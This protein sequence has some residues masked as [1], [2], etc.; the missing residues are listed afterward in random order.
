METQN[1]DGADENGPGHQ[2]DLLDKEAQEIKQEL[3]DNI[4]ACVVN[5]NAE[6]EKLLNTATYRKSKL[7][8]RS[9]QPI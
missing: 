3:E 2:I 6:Q 5:V 9:Q 1:G 8:I 4:K 7:F